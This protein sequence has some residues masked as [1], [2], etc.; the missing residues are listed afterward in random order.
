MIG[1]KE[2]LRKA[3]LEISENNPILIPVNQRGC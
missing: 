1:R 3:H 2:E